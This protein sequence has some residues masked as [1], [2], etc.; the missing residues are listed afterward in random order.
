MVGAVGLKIKLVESQENLFHLL[1]QI[2]SSEQDYGE[3]YCQVYG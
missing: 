3:D 2:C 1:T